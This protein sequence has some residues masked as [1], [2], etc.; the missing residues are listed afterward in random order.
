M[1]SLSTLVV[2]KEAEFAPCTVSVRANAEQRYPG[3]VAALPEVKSG[4]SI[5]AS[6]E[7]TGDNWAAIHLKGEDSS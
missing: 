6:S 3:H 7:A 4:N 2:F 5:A 1:L